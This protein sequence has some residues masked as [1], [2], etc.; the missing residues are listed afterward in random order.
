MAVRPKRP[1]GGRKLF[2]KEPETVLYIFHCVKNRG[3]GRQTVIKRLN[4]WRAHYYVAE[5]GGTRGR[6]S[7]TG[8]KKDIWRERVARKEGG[9]GQA[10]HYR[11][12]G[13][14]V[15]RIQVPTITIPCKVNPIIRAEIH[16][17]S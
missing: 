5:G 8:S 1:M 3:T 4:R 6:P 11:G 12:M 13:S 15:Q 2:S 9:I 7:L 16:G 10:R 17:K 14:K